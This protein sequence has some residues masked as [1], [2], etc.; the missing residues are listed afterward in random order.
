MLFLSFPSFSP[1]PPDLVQVSFSITS[2]S[3]CALSSS[4]SRTFGSRELDSH[5]HN[6]KLRRV[7]APP[8]SNVRFYK[9]Y[10]NSPC[11]SAVIHQC[12]P[13]SE[14]RCFSGQ[15]DATIGKMGMKCQEA[16]Q[17]RKTKRVCHT[18]SSASSA[19]PRA[20]TLERYHPRAAI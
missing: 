5:F 4:W 2:R 11:Y 13:R 20:Q 6:N 1:P 8:N 12:V 9:T 18:T 15:T 7:L 3:V 19:V 10:S 16:S 14:P 17:D